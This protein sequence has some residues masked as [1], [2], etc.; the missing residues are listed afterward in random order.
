MSKFL[1]RVL[2]CLA[3]AVMPLAFNAQSYQVTNANF[4]DWSAAAFDGQPQ[5]TGWHASN[6]EQVGMKFNFAHKETGHNGGYCMMVQDQSVGAMGISETS[7]GY[8]S[9]GQPWAYLPSITQVNQA[10]AGTSGGQSWTH[11]PDTMSVWIKRTGSNTDKEDFYLL[12]YAWVKEAKGT[13]Y[14]G[15][16][17][18]C[19]SHSETN[20]ESDVRKAMNGNECSTTVDGEQVCE[21]MWRERKTY[22][23]WTNIRVPIYYFNNNAPKYMNII[24]SASNYPNFRA[25]S[26]LYEG[27][28]LYVDDVELIYSSKIQTLRI[29]NKEWK[30]FDPNNTTGVQVYSVGDATSIPAIEAYRGAGS[31]TNAAGTTKSFPGR[32]LSGSEISI[33]YGNLTGTPTVITVHA[34]DGSSTTTYRIQ[35]Q[36]AASSN[37][38]LAS[39]SYSY[40]DINGVDH[41]ENIADFS[42][43]T[44]NYQIELPYGATAIG[45]VGYVQQEDSQH[46]NVTQPLSLTGTAKLEVTAENGKTKKSYNL[47]FSI[48]QLADNTLAGITVNGKAVPGFTPTQTVYRVSLP[49]GTPS[50][51]I[52]P[53]SAYGPGEQTI[54]ITPNPL[55]TGADIDGSTVKVSVTTPGNSVPKEYKLNLKLEASSYSRLADLQVTGTQIQKV[56]PGNPDDQTVLAFDPD[57]TTYYVNLQLGTTELPTISWTPGDEYQTITKSDLGAGVVDGT[58]RI[59]VKAGNNSDQTD[60]KLVFSTEK[61]DRSTLN[62]IVIG[63]D[64]LAGFDPD[65]LSYSYPLEI[66]TISLPTIEPIPGDEY[67]TISVTPAGVNGKTRITVTAGDGSTSVYQIA[68]SVASYTDNTLKS[69]SVAGYDIGFDPL[70]DEYTVSLPQGTNTLPEVTY[71]AQAAAPLQNVAVRSLNPSV[72]NGDYKITV[73]PQSGASRTYII[74]FSVATSSN[75]DLEMIYLNGTPLP[76]F[77]ADSLHYIDSLPE[78][79]STIPTVTFKKAEAAQRVLSV[80]SGKTQTI[81]VTAESGAKRVYVIDF[82]VRASENAFLEMIYL[83]SVALPGFKKDS[84]EYTVM[85][86]NDQLCPEITV[87]KAAGQQVTVTTPYAAGV[88]KVVVKPESGST[89]EYKITFKVAAAQ[90]VQLTDILVDNIS[91]TGFDKDITSYDLPYQNSL[92]TVAGVGTPEQTVNVLWKDSVAWIHV[93]DSVGTKAA[94]SVTFHRAFSANRVLQ[95]IYANGVLIAGFHADSLHYA[96]ELAPGSSYPEVTYKAADQAQV[97]FFGQVAEG[98]WEITV[99]A[100]NGVK[101]TYDL[102]YTI[103]KYSDVTLAGLSVQGQYFAFMPTKKHYSFELDNGAALP[104]LTV[105]PR[106]GQNIMQYNESDSVQRILVDAENGDTTSYTITYTRV[107]SS[108]TTLAAI[109]VDGDSL[110]GFD[111]DVTHYVDTIATYSKHV[112][113]VYPI[114]AVSTQTVTTTYSLPNGVTK[115]HVL[116]QNGDTKD[117]FI[118]FPV[119]KSSNTKL[120]EIYLTSEDDVD[121]NFKANQTNYTVILPFDATTCPKM[122]IKKG[123]A[124][125]RI[126]VI[127]RPIGETSQ[128]IV[129]AENGD[130]RTYNILFKRAVLKTANVLQS[131][132]IKE[133][134]KNLSKV[135]TLRNYDVELPYGTRSL[136]VEYEKSYDAQTVFVQPG[137]VSAPTII[138]VKANND[139]IEDVVYT[140]TP[141]VSTQNPAVLNSIRVDGEEVADFEPNRFTYIVN[142]TATTY[143]KVTVTRNSGVEYDPETSLQ[144]WEATVSK[145][146]Y[147]NKYQVFFHYTNDVIPNGEFTEWTKTSESNTDKPKC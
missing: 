103:G 26:G 85:L 50:L 68:F 48:G 122:E 57:V 6:V 92:P 39:I 130:T 129:H 87:K 119:R 13:S 146:G 82:I 111:P 18:S 112:P 118:S 7:P 56:T 37:A 23:N 115:I 79:V 71:E 34:E 67:Q 4:E 5:A 124:E 83:D 78:G 72:L 142:R 123:E 46:V 77:R 51:S 54:V 47:T 106:P 38:N 42:P 120:E 28:S 101:A 29:D 125:Q 17:G 126:D 16:N 143:P 30:G 73:R 105:T 132:Y 76:G 137:G 128:V 21:G 55:P 121:F 147:E 45:Q 97:V 3:T 15:K 84:L 86:A 74:H 99:V 25:N 108:T 58:V 24:F 95:G 116:A 60:Y 63:G 136:T 100:E 98:K 20:E 1:Q 88:A 10:T 109:F 139:T 33:Q 110:Q 65:V 31:L 11:R 32:K 145:D 135:K 80:L 27:N 94:Y 140:L 44:Y 2:V 61:S 114:P 8:F 64:T 14:K 40:T 69:L 12:Y 89:N 62:G 117:Y 66:G 134:D 75:T 96:Y 35:F 41:T 133:A 127:S 59:I 49:V 93:S 138:T 90:S 102:Q 70:Q 81:T 104:V 113:N 53:V 141:I 43:T 19:T 36:Q 9:I 91:L 52:Q 131:I 144:K 107:L 22:G